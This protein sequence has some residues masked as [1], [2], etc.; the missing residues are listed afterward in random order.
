MVRS[1]R[2]ISIEDMLTNLKCMS[3]VA[4]RDEPVGNVQPEPQLASLI[5]AFSPTGHH[6]FGGGLEEFGVG[7]PAAAASA[8]SLSGAVN[9][10]S[11]M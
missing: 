6:V 5:Y 11:R 8:C 3:G 7:T 9:D 4:S 10:M 1:R 2:E